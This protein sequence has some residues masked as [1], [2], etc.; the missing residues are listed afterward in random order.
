M[1]DP[2][3]VRAR[4]CSLLDLTTLHATDQRQDVVA[5][6]QHAVTPGGGLPSVA[7]VCVHADRADVAVSMLDGTPVRVA[8]VA[9]AF[10]HARSP[11]AIRAAEIEHVVALG[12]DEVDVPID[13]A[14]VL[15]SQWGELASELATL[16]K[17]AGE[18]TLK[19]ILET[20][21]ISDPAALRH[22]CAT[23]LEAGADFLK[24]STGQAGAATPEATRVLLEAVREQRRGGVKVAGGVRS[25]EQATG[26]LAQADALWGTATADTFRIGA[27]S[28]LDALVAA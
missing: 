18:A 28:L 12:V 7:A 26:Y 17:A 22:A 27:S 10:P 9:G 1:T 14:K 5:L 2:S 6:C 3:G 16:R 4:L 20:A 24:T 19:V 11:L 21:E 23:A 8:A 25:L 15:A 13:R